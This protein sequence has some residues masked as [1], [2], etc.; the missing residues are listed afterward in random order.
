MRVTAHLDS[1]A[2]GLDTWA[3]PLDGPLSWA[4]AMR[5]LGRGEDIP[6]TP[7]V[8]TPAADFPL[9]LERW[10]RD[11]WWGWRSSRA[12][13]DSPTH[14]SIEVRRKPATGPMSVWT[15]DARH[16]TGLG[17][18]KARNVTRS[19]IVTSTMW[20]D[21]E[22]SDPDDLADLL[23]CVTHLGA[24]HNAGFGHVSHWTLDPIL[25]DWSDR[26]WPPAV[27]CRAPYW[28]PSRRRLDHE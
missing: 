9:P 8:S 12:H 27:A 5:A 4:F 15:R 21:V 6:P 23:A 26:D 10:E 16:H 3:T 1:A 24:R 2:V 20:W 17:P 18:M 19:A 14:T 11:G 28:H 25:G 22:P 13:F 7:T